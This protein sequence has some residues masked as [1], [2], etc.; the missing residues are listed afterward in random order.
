M[1][2][3]FEIKYLVSSIAFKISWIENVA[4]A[5]TQNGSIFGEAIIE[6]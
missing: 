2:W 6:S 5:I 3:Y 4:R 1:D